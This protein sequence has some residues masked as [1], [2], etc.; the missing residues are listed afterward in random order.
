[1]S[2]GDQLALKTTTGYTGTPTLIRGKV[3][4]LR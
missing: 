3:R 2:I 1:M 4:I